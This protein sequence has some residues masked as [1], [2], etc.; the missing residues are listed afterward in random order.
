MDVGAV[1]L[2][3]SIAAAGNALRHAT[4]QHWVPGD[5]SGPFVGAG[6]SSATCTVSLWPSDTP[7]CTCVMECLCV[8]PSGA[9]FARPPLGS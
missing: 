4:S 3:M 8:W 2:T 1:G 7:K 5:L 9:C 6:V